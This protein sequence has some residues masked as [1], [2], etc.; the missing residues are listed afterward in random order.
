MMNDTLTIVLVI[1]IGIPAAVIA[2]YFVVKAARYAW[3]AA[4]EQFTEDLNNE[5]KRDENGKPEQR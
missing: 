5:R 3:L 4:E 2:T 1:A